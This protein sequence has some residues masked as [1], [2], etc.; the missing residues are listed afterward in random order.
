MDL[1]L[2]RAIR[3]VIGRAWD[4]IRS[5]LDS[6][7]GLHFCLAKDETDLS[8]LGLALGRRA[9]FDIVQKMLSIYPDAVFTRDMFGASVLHIACLNGTTSEIIEA[10]LSINKEMIYWTDTDHRIPLHHAVEFA[11]GPY[12]A[13]NEHIG[14][15]VVQYLCNF[16]PES[17]HFSTYCN[18]TPI[19]VVQMMKS[20]FPDETSAEFQRIE[21]VY[22]LL[23]SYSISVYLNMKRGWEEAGHNK[24]LPTEDA[25]K[26]EQ[27]VRSGY[28]GTVTK[29]L[30]TRSECTPQR[31]DFK[32]GCWEYQVVSRT[33]T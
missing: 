33:D 28:T 8:I 23:T 5:I 24:E 31:F 3:L 4:P 9:P 6:P 25:D 7:M 13:T 11:C 16:S 22:H 1:Q 32:E 26:L 20:N 30:C 21:R 12:N 17:V 14:F 10:V 19:D 18:D 15:G 2:K 27:S 29:S